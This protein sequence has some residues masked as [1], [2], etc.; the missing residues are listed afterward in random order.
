MNEKI[1]VLDVP[2]S[3]YT[4]KEAMKKVMEYMQTEPI[5]IIEMVTMNTLV[6]LFDKEEQKKYIDE[7]EFT[8]V[9]DKSILEAAGVTDSKYL[10]EADTLLFVKMLMRFLHKNHNKVFLLA[11][12]EESLRILKDYVED[13]YSGIKIAETATMEEHGKS[14]DMIVNRINGAEVDC[15]LVTLPSPL[16]EEI[17]LRNR[18]LLNARIW[19]GLGMELREKQTVSGKKRLKTFFTQRIM[20]KKIEKEQKQNRNL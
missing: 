9:G 12:N 18:L 11:E 20:K 2:I 10:K 4:A 15:I 16:Q 5:S 6:Q 17:I 19:F 1:K 14:D 13:N 7:F 3:N 8:F